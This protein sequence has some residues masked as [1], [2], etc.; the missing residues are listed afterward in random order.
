MC[1][2]KQREHIR[3]QDK[4][5]QQHG[6]HIMND[7]TTPAPVKLGTVVYSNDRYSAV[8][9]EITDP[10]SKQPVVLYGVVNIETGVREAELRS[11]PHAVGWCD[12]LDDAVKKLDEVVEQETAIKEALGEPAIDPETAAYLLDNTEH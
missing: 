8:I 6:D 3:D 1:T 11:Y 4:K 10:E 12:Q 7:V 2:R 9:T 5:T